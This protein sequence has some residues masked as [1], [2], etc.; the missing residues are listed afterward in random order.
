VNAVRRRW[1]IVVLVL[2]VVVLAVGAATAALALTHSG[3]FDTSLPFALAAWQDRH[4]KAG[5]RL[6]MAERLVWRHALDGKSRAEVLSMLGPHLSK[7]G[8]PLGEAFQLRDDILGAFGDDVV[9]VPLLQTN[10]IEAKLLALGPVPSDE[11]DARRC[12]QGR[13]FLSPARGTHC[14]LLLSQTKRT[15]G[16]FFLILVP[17]VTLLLSDRLS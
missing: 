5:V 3:P 6:R 4:A 11:G 9:V 15:R 13:G 2:C 12:Q 16:V 7:F 17:S 14:S 10:G 8:A 1:W